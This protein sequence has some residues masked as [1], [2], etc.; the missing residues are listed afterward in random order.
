MRGGNADNHA[1]SSHRRTTPLLIAAKR[2]QAF[3]ILATACENLAIC[4]DAV[5]MP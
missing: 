2:N 5:Q 3:R 4:V 1:K